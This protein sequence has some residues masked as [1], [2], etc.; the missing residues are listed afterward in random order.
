MLELCSG[1]APQGSAEGS[2]DSLAGVRSQEPAKELILELGS[3][4]EEIVREL[5]RGP[6]GLARNSFNNLPEIEAKRTEAE[7]SATEEDREVGCRRSKE[8]K[9]S[10][11][12]E[13]KDKERLA[14][15]PTMKR[16]RPCQKR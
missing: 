15:E 7:R 16:L 2:I 9:R 13:D 12:E 6:E 11:A 4:V 14:T 8:P 5:G 1:R 10:A 3:L